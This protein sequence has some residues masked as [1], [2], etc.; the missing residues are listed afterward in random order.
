MDPPKFCG[1]RT[2]RAI[3]LLV[4]KKSKDK[5]GVNKIMSIRRIKKGLQNRKSFTL[6]ERAPSKDWEVVV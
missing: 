4:Y 6:I 3:N 2:E 5:V 1:G